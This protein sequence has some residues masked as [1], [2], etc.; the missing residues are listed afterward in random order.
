MT[1][2]FGPDG[3]VFGHTG[4]FETEETIKAKETK[5]DLEK[6]EQKIVTIVCS[7]EEVKSFEALGWHVVTDSDLMCGE[8]VDYGK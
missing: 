8:E 5:S 7:V 3:I 4:R 1:I 6:E 2:Y